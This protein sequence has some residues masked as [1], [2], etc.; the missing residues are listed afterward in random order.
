MRSKLIS[1]QSG[2]TAGIVHKLLNKATSPELKEKLQQFSMQLVHL[3]VQ[4][5]A[6][7]LFNID[8]TLYFTICGAV[9]TY[10]IILLQFTN[11]N[12]GQPLGTA[13]PP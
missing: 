8:R 9:T 2:K 10:L 12:T 5:T 4:F 7:G 1:F 11:Q 3:K 13:L 6:A